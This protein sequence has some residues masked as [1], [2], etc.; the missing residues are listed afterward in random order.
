MEFID[1]KGRFLG[2]V[3]VFDLAVISLL[4]VSAVFAFKWAHMA[5]DPSFVNVKTSYTFCEA[6][7]LF[8]AFMADAVKAGD[9]MRNEDGAVVAR[10]EKVLSNGPAS[11]IVYSSKE[12][13]KL[14][15]NS[16]KNSITVRLK[17]QSYEKKGDM[18]SGISGTPIRPGSGF[19]ITTKNYSNQFT[20][21][22][23]LSAGE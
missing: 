6:E 4:A 13:E 12:G 11:T 1:K 20:V 14:F 18:Y 23:I 15:F 3:N 9:E 2:L 5:D 22:K 21:R 7:S 17:L 19:L 8:P 16:E 10:V